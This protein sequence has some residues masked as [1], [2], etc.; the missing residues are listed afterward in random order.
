MVVENFKEAM[1]PLIYPYVSG[2]CVL[3]QKSLSYKDSGV[4][5][6]A[7]DSLVSLIKPLARYV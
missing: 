1:H 5:I 6:E 4:D 7:G 2:E 3:P